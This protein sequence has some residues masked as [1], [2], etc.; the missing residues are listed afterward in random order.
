LECQGFAWMTYHKILC[1]HYTE[2]IDKLVPMEMYAV[3]ILAHVVQDVQRE[4]TQNQMID[5]ME[6]ICKDGIGIWDHLKRFCYC[7]F[8]ELVA[9][10]QEKSKELFGK[11]NE[12]LREQMI[13]N[14]R[15]V[16]DKIIPFLQSE[17]GI[18]SNT[19]A[20]SSSSTAT[21][22]STNSNN[23]DKTNTTKGKL[24]P[25]YQFLREPEF[26]FRLCGIA[27]RNSIGAPTSHINPVNRT[28]TKPEQEEGSTLQ[29]QED[30]QGKV[31][32]KGKGI[33][34]GNLSK[35][36]PE[37]SIRALC[38]LMSYF[39]HSCDPNIDTPYSVGAGHEFQILTRR[40]I[41]EGEEL[42]ISYIPERLGFAQRQRSLQ[43][44]YGFTCG[45]LRCQ[46]EA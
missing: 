16:V 23:N 3:R 9:Y 17:S 26:F 11:D 21:P 40:P 34:R 46:R 27:H 22:T 8:D 12:G 14:V 15:F 39:N 38:P 10:N 45:C 30:A 1:P 31:K 25:T 32:D 37:D 35:D 41:K 2:L 5:S 18:Q 13:E 6:N 43:L 19:E 44:G 4:G 20:S 36:E 33:G 29:R 7:S 24:K 42:C 28:M